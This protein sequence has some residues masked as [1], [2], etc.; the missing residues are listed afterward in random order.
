MSVSKSITGLV[1]G[2]LAGR[3]ALDV[4]AAVETSSPSS[5]PRPSA[6]RP[7]SS[8]S[9][10]VQAPGSTRT[11]PIRTP[12]SAVSDRVYL[13]SPDDGRPRPADALEFF[14][15]LVNDGAHGGPFRYRS[16]LVDVL[17]WVLERAAG[18]RF[19]DLVAGRL[20]QPMGAEYDA[21]IT[22]D[23][24][25]NPLADGGISATLRDAG[26][27]G[28]LALQR[29]R[30]GARGQRQV[31]PASGSTTP[32][33][34]PP[35]ARV[36]SPRATAPAR[37]PAARTTATA[38]GSPIRRSPCSTPRHSRSAHLRARPQPDRG[39]EAVELAGRAQLGAA[40]GHGRRRHRDRRR[41]QP[42]ESEH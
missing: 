16:I 32:S 25:G 6:A 33:R 30:A 24:H 41:P 34:A 39:G 20:W 1:A 9:T 23:A 29:G 3:G 18:E 31:V 10:C 4:S 12:S 14:T 11:T 7:C 42:P 36:R 15:T 40:P 26:R 28:Q 35:T 5:R 17:A 19:A 37:T 8:C 38:G 2:A 22:V 13:W 27:I 21:E